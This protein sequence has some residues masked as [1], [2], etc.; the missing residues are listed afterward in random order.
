[1]LQTV[2]DNDG[3]LVTFTIRIRDSIETG[4]IDIP[5]NPG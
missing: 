3:M 1:M 2:A 4:K 5:V